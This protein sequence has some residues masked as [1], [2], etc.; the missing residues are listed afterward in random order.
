MS[1]R[2]YWLNDQVYC[3]NVGEGAILLDLQRERYFGVPRREAQILCGIVNEWPAVRDRTRLPVTREDEDAIA[4]VLVRRGLLSDRESRREI[5]RLYVPASRSAFQMFEMSELRACV[6]L[7]VCTRFAAAYVVA[8]MFVRGHTMRNTVARLRQRQLIASASWRETHLLEL[9][10]HFMKLRAL[11]YTA[12]KQCMLDSLVLSEFLARNRIVSTF[13][14]G[15][16]T[17]SFGAHCWV[18]VGD[19]VLNDSVEHVGSYEPILFV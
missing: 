4:D 12:Y 5:S 18:Q 15:V 6:P 14:I 9:V 19:L 7:K 13:V 1:E 17:R 10:V 16:K 8:C 2:R 3:S 11:A